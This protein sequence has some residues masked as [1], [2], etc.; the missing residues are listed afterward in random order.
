MMPV[1]RDEQS[2]EPAEESQQAPPGRANRPAMTYRIVLERDFIRAE[3]AH[4]ETVEEMREFLRALVRNSARCPLILIRVRASKPLFHVERG[5]LIDFLQQIARAP[6][7]RIALLADTPDLQASHEYL[8]LIARQRGVRVRSFRSEAEALLW[9]KD[10]RYLGERRLQGVERRQDNGRRQA[11][12][13]RT[14]AERRRGER[15]GQ[16]T[17]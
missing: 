2:K 8:E 4:R 16:S 17:S 1:P 7:H 13:R 12:E 14:V 10:R 5:G 3:L 6:Q 11:L 15:R 9:F